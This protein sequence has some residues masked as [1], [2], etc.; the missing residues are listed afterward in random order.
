M[1]S[2]PRAVHEDAGSLC[3]EVQI[4]C[5][6]PTT[7]AHSK[8]VSFVVYKSVISQIVRK[9][10]P[11]AVNFVFI[12]FCSKNQETVKPAVPALPPPAQ[13]Q[14][15]QAQQQ[16]SQQAAAAP[17]TPTTQQT[18]QPSTSAPATPLPPGNAVLLF[19]YFAADVSLA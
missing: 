7:H 11:S 4:Y 3:A 17:Q 8:V 16:Q 12:L 10:E 18:P 15:S 2:G 14:T 1:H 6:S 13:P 19:I 9:C 5:R